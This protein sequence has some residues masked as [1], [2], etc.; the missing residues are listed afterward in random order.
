MLS[1]SIV[2]RKVSPLTSAFS[3][4][5]PVMQKV[6][7]G[8]GVN[9]QEEIDYSL[10]NLL[11]FKQ[12]KNIDAA[13]RLL[14][15]SLEQQRRIVIVADYDADGAT[16]CALAIRGLKSMG[17]ANVEFIV[18]DRFI[19]GYGLS[20]E[21]VELASRLEPDL[22]LTVDN[23][24]SSVDGVAL[25]RSKGIDVLIT[26][27]HIPAKELPD[28]NVI[29]NPNLIDD[30]FPSKSIAGVGVMFYVL[31]ALRASLSETDWFETK[32]RPAP[33][34]SQFLDL[35]ALGTV[36]DVVKL[37]LN[38]RILVEQGLQRIRQGQCTPGI[39][40]LL[41][42]AQR[43]PES[44]VSSDLGFIVG[45]RLNAAGRLTDMRLGIDCLLCDDHIEAT[46]MA[47]RLDQLN[48]ERREIQSEME[49]EAKLELR[50]FSFELNN[51]S[52]FGMCLY[53]EHWH[54]GVIGVLAS[55]IKEMTGRPV[56]A[57]AKES[58]SS[59]KGS[60]RSVKNVHIR[61]VFDAIATNSP[62]L[63][64]TFGGHAMA[65]GLSINT[66]NYDEFSALFNREVRSCFEKSGIDSEL[67]SDGELN[68]EYINL[69][70][71]GIIRRSGPWGQ[72]FPEPVF[73]GKFRVVESR[74]LAK[75]HLKLLLSTDD[76]KGQVEA[77]AFNTT[78][79]DWPKD[80]QWVEAAY[81]LEVNDYRGH[82]TPQLIIEYIVPSENDR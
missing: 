38:N 48:K 49:A 13:A 76:N 69:D 8:R 20:P 55:K 5:H 66:E 62:G 6:Y 9:K 36:D 28:A 80:Y 26:D 70:L 71:A 58:E 40:A 39:S 1:K 45:P 61:D 15:S 3:D 41:S 44:V 65:A 19:H 2:R 64:N 60:A 34:L 24:I 42:M 31:A 27:H 17:A 35:V 72:G 73:D 67:V 77:I 50:D 81:R 18:P 7:A 30:V 12:I 4:L 47:T 33:R 32:E 10:K 78:D 75:K 51:S 21:I 54:Q 25:A 23:G 63:I 79:T 43:L 46:R 22:L 11:G 53:K 74:L 14:R 29:V 82:R 56:I 59:L 57:F 68:S 37:D 52:T 16:A